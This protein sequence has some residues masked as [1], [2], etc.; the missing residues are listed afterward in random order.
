MKSEQDEP[1]EELESGA[2]AIAVV[3]MAG[4]FPG[5][6]DLDEFWENLRDGVE[7]ISRLT[8]EELEA[9]G[10][11]PALA[12]H[13][14][15]VR[16]KG[17]LDRAEH[18]DAPFFNLSPR[19]ARITDPQQRL[20]LEHAWQA[21]E[22]A[23]CDPSR[24][25]G[26]IGVFGGSSM[27]S[28]LLSNLLFNPE[29]ATAS[30]LELRIANDRD[31]LSTAVSY[32]LNLRG[33]SINVATACSTSLVAIHLACQSLLNRE[34]DA[35]LVGGVSV[36]FPQR[37]GYLW[38]K[39]G[40]ASADGHCRAFDARAT[41]TVGG[42]GVGVIFL[43]RLEDALA[44]G[45]PVR[46]VIKGSAVNNDGFLKVGFTAPSVQGQAEVIAEAQAIAGVEPESISYVETHGSG[47]PLGDSVEMRALN[48]AFRSAGQ[49][50]SCAVGSLKTAIGHLD[51]A[52][53]VAGLIKTVLALEH[54][55]LPPTL[56][57][58]APNPELEIENGPFYVNAELRPWE[59]PEGP[60]RAGVS[61]FGIGGSNAHVILEE[62]PEPEPPGPSARSW[63][64]M[65]LSAATATALEAV[66]E[67]LGEHVASHPEQSLADVA[68]T[69]QV[70][71]KALGHRR[72]VVC[73]DREDAVA[74]LAGWASRRLLTGFTK[75]ER[76][77][78]FL[79]SGLGDHYPGMGAGLYQGEAVFRREV[80]RCAEIL[81]P[82]LGEDLR[83]V[84]FSHSQTP[85]PQAT[86]DP[87]LRRMLGRGPVA[88]A[89][90]PLERPTLLHSSIFVLE[91][92]LA[93]LWDAMGVRPRA[94][95]G[96]SLGE[97][98][99]ATLAG[100]FS[101]EDALRLVAERARLIERLPEGA[102]LAV[103]LGEEE[104]TGLL[105]DTLSLAA[106]NASGVCVVAGPVAPVEALEAHLRER[107]LACRR[108]PVR[109]ALHSSMMEPILEPFARLIEGV[110][111]KAPKLPYVTGVTG[112]WVTP[113]QATS[114]E[115]WVRH[116]RQT[117]RFSEG[118][119]TLWQDPSTALVEVG[120]GQGLTTLALQ[121]G[122]G[123]GDRVALPSL[124][125]AYEAHDDQAFLLRSLG[126]LWTVGVE[127]AWTRF[128]AGEPRRKVR[129]PTYPFERQPYLIERP[130]RRTEKAGLALPEGAG[131][132]EGPASSESSST[133]HP[134]PDLPVPYLAPR[135]ETEEA[136][137]A[138]WRE[139]LHLETV[140][141]H[142]SFFQLGGHS[143]LAS[144]V[145]L[146]L[147]Q[148]AGVELPLRALLERPTIA[149]I[150]ETLERLRQGDTAL[151]EAAPD[152][153][154]EIVL[155][156]SIRFGS[157]VSTE[158]P[159]AVLLTGA[160]G[161][162]GAFLLRDLLRET[163][164]AV[165]C[166]ARAKDADSALDRIRE[167]LEAYHLWE[168][169]LAERIIPVTGDLGR[170]L[171][172]MDEASF[173]ALAEH[174]EAVYHAGAWVNFTYP[175]AAL[176]PVNVL[177]TI[178]TLRLAAWGRGGTPIHFVSS[179]AAFAPGSF[180][181]EGVGLETSAL[182]S[183]E[184]L[185]GGYGASKWVAEK[186]L[187]AARERGLETTVYRPGA[188]GG[189]SATGSGN[190]KDLIW[191]F[192]KGCL[193]LG[194]SPEIDA[195]FEPAP[196]DWVS[197]AIVTLSRNKQSHGKAF[198]LFNPRP[199]PWP[200]VFA[201][202]RSLGYPVREVPLAVWLDEL[203]RA[204]RSGS[205]NAL[206]PFWPLLTGEMGEQPLES[207]RRFDDRNTREGLAGTSVACPSAGELLPT[208]F[209]FLIGS[210]FLPPP[211]V[212]G[213]VHR[214]EPRGRLAV[215]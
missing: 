45:D 31:F 187:A 153:R 54:R 103:P 57:F 137:A 157:T 74:A 159:A 65:L 102:M 172:G 80:D 120:P 12:D 151:D 121:H 194:A 24:F 146:R 155:D 37:I 87:D 52:A 105:G 27:S 93:K 28:Y 109:R 29:V 200:E 75:A 62:A 174:V 39:G 181:A 134:R 73:D 78:A 191:A 22:D 127:V 98:T 47:T 144:Q 193:E 76:P 214:A 122:A 13:P 7:A 15:Y 83:E 107:G 124:R 162:L 205:E 9:E 34:C 215:Q 117:V 201:F 59:S 198:H 10:V 139:A 82:I 161:F 101:L 178:E 140:G 106:V 49:E 128:H 70:G 51:A 192:L 189:D 48:R 99:A 173:R 113:A 32:R 125:S 199:V 180:S 5:A 67:R 204:I 169:A 4:R 164:A 8:R 150:G 112:T 166:L 206:A 64:L 209:N 130:G 165:H 92:A 149:E 179:I 72:A 138:V 168:P 143:L 176:K 175:Y 88:D 90:S 17:V 148:V 136:V 71:R 69:T 56:H 210:G 212:A 25:A 203:M 41:G 132:P 89:A 163:R 19:E 66:S 170:P 184:G 68:Y 156:E 36:S 95:L 115:H 190:P 177:G 84:L 108:L 160:T 154:S 77:V 33:P 167:N 14:D 195:V 114:P 197:R 79:L 135:N 11:D 63:S 94:L 183:T 213:L 53:G 129:L 81:R 23:G 171:W 50:K 85:Q 152:L 118:I 202:A 104:L 208:Y 21:L 207:G 131:A 43:R 40:I 186:L 3:G 30:A 123:R 18:F 182:E 142:D 60:R 58:E 96:Y 55:Q 38:Q 185:F 188:I 100:V 196:V 91:H 145:A 158:E 61:S 147:E 1:G 20:F 97:L 16:A 211:P 42:E 116:L 2:E 110:R 35:A 119:A 44:D 111:M 26:P 141:V 46:A 126:R 6:E 86:G 133:L